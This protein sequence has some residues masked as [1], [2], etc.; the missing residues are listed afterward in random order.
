M[1]HGV[2]SGRRLVY[3]I[4]VAVADE[5]EQQQMLQRRQ[6]HHHMPG[7]GPHAEA[8]VSGA[9][10]GGQGQ[11]DDDSTCLWLPTPT[12]AVRL[13]ELDCRANPSKRARSV[14]TRKQS[15]IAVRERKFG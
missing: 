2:T 9:L 13:R 7:A 5:S 4:D 1:E 8:A 14:C 12:D 3:L 15:S 10:L 11:R 6:L